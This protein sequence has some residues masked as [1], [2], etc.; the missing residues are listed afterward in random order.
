MR[1]RVR[2]PAG[3]VAVLFAV[4]VCTSC[5]HSTSEHPGEVFNAKTWKDFCKGANDSVRVMGPGP[6]V[7]FCGAGVARVAWPDGGSCYDNMVAEH[8]H[9]EAIPTPPHP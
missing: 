7:V 4:S 5:H 2:R 9:E 3:W 6:C 1:M 8:Y